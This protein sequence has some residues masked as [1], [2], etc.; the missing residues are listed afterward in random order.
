MVKRIARFA[1]LGCIIAGLC[2]SAVPYPATAALPPESDTQEG[3]IVF[4]ATKVLGD[5]DGVDAAIIPGG[6][7]PGVYLARDYDNLDPGPWALLGG[8]YT[9]TWKELE[10]SQGVYNWSKIDDFISALAAKGKPAGLHITTYNG[11]RGGVGIPDWLVSLYPSLVFTTVANVGCNTTT[12]PPIQAPRYWDSRYLTAYTNFINALGA[13]YTSDPRVEFVL[14]GTGLYGETQPGDDCYD[15]AFAAQGLTWDLWRTHVREVS[16]AYAIAFGGTGNSIRPPS[17]PLMILNAP[18]YTHRCNRK[19]IMEDVGPMGIGNLVAGLLADEDAVLI[20]PPYSQ[21]Y[22]GRLDPMIAVQR[23]APVGHE[24]YWYLTPHPILAYWGLMG[25]LGHMVD[26]QS[27]PVDYVSVDYSA[28][29]WRGWMFADA[30]GN[31]RT[32]V[33]EYFRWAQPYFGKTAANAPSVWVAM[34]ET[35]YTWYPQ[36][37]NYSYYLYQDDTVAGGQTKAVTY[38]RAVDPDDASQAALVNSLIPKDSGTTYNTNIELN[39]SLGGAWGGKES[40]IT[41]RTQQASG[42]RY[43][44]FKIDDGFMFGGTNTVTIKVTYFDYGTDTWKIDYDAVG[45]IQKSTSNVIKTNSRTWKTQTFVLTDAR[46]GNGLLGSSDFRIDCNNDG[47]EYIHFVD[48][49]KGG[50]GTV[51][52]DIPLRTGWNFVSIPLTLASTNTETVLLPISGKY[53]KVYA[54]NAFD[55]VDPWKVYDLSLPPF[56][57]DLTEINHTKG[58]WLYAT[59]NSTWTINGSWP[60][61]TSIPLKTGWNLIGYPGQTTKTVTDALSSIAGKYTKVYTYVAFDDADPWKVYDI[62]LPVFLNDLT[63]IQAGRAY[64]IWVTQDC[65]LMV[66]N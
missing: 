56:L 44:W 11:R 15:N 40:W 27:Y 6:G 29:D 32:E 34:R 12:Y 63:H 59:Q 2:I 61:S 62:S 36:K 64:W 5:P 14:V 9:F 35:G 66:T 47:D 26:G 4:T 42:N 55:T 18:T 17:K 51:N 1:L 10:P 48:V 24:A 54:Y 41:R 49:S 53:S 23:T 60:G 50:G 8:Q 46:M 31:P 21:A 45:G 57:N 37:G 28:T 25:A 38:R 3:S 39:V 65:T 43:M 30:D 22:C 20:T 7:R 16:R 58:L 52:F 33:I 19:E 13:R